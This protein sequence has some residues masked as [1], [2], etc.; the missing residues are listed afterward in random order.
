MGGINKIQRISGNLNVLALIFFSPGPVVLGESCGL[1]NN[2]RW[3]CDSFASLHPHPRGKKPHNLEWGWGLSSLSH[4]G[5]SKAGHVGS[6]RCFSFNTSSY[7]L[8]VC[9]KIKY[10]FFF[11]FLYS[12]GASS[13]FVNLVKYTHTVVLISGMVRKKRRK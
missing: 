9:G 13:Q 12:F 7:L 11:F 2:R 5:K 8:F 10:N 6:F 3:E 1:N 4:W